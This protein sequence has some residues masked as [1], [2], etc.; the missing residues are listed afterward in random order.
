MAS[1]EAFG[2]A[3]APLATGAAG[4]A[5][6]YLKDTQKTP[7]AHVD[8]LTRLE[9]SGHL[10]M[11]ES[12]RANLEVLK[13]LRDG[14]RKGSLLGVL[15]RT[16][17]SMGGRKLARWLASPLCA[18]PE[19]H[20]RLDAVEELAGAQRLARGADHAPQGGGGPG[21]A[22]RPA[23]AGRWQRAGSARP[24]GLARAAA[25]AGRGA[26][27]VLGPAARARWRGRWARCRSWRIC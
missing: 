23:L 16:A 20:A 8:R 18:L 19:I 24:G 10:L 26:V 2:L 27:A 9:R 25:Q 17:T 3:E 4:A 5:L 21:A 1:L 6:R 11:D 7:A 22:V 14:A 12:S 15:D 13:T